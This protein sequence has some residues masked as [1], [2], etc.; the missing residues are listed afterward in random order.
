MRITRCAQN[1]TD[2]NISQVPVVQQT[3]EVENDIEIGGLWHSTYASMMKDQSVQE[4][5]KYR[6]VRH[7]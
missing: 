6:N 3:K 7:T 4:K 1:K 2:K 5:N